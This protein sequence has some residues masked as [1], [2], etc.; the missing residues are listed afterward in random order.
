MKDSVKRII[1]MISQL[2]DYQQTILEEMI[3]IIISSWK[4]PE[5]KKGTED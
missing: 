3:E 5:D 2:S 1:S 4:D